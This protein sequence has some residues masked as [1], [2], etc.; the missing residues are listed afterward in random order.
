MVVGKRKEVRLAL[1]GRRKASS[2]LGRGRPDAADSLLCR[3]LTGSLLKLAVK[4]NITA[5]L[6]T[7]K[8]GQGETH[9]VLG[10]CTH[11]PGSLKISLLNG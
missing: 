6:L 3:P 4:L 2:A 8:D 1:Q 11:S 10:D 9:L 7:V 5:E